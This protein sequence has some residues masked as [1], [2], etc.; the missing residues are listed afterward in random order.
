MEYSALIDSTNRGFD[1]LAEGVYVTGV[2]EDALEFHLG[3]E[4]LFL[5]SSPLLAVRWGVWLDPD[6]LVRISPDIDLGSDEVHFALGLGAAFERFQ[7]DL[8]ADFSDLV[9]TLSLSTIVSF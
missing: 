2:I 3:A 1:R 7:I 8:A 4:Y 5:E 9:D 6:H